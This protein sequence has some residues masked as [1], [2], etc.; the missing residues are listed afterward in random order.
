MEAIMS[1]AEELQHLRLVLIKRRDALRKVL[2]NDLVLLRQPCVKPGDDPGCYVSQL[3][4]VESREL[5]RIGHAL[6]RMGKGQYGVCETCGTKIPMARL[7]ALPYANLCIKCQREWE[8]QVVVAEKVDWGK[9]S[10][11]P[12]TDFELFE[13][14]ADDA[15]PTD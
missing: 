15:E 12:E 2:E 1:R 5:D 3:A 9:V 11:S 8:L 10:D 14:S 4:E 6:E 7:N 13:L